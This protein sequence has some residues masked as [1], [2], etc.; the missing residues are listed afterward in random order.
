MSGRRIYLNI[1]HKICHILNPSLCQIC[2][3]GIKPGGFYCAQCLQDFHRVQNACQLCGLPNSAGGSICPACLF[4]PPPWQLMIAPLIYAGAVRSEIQ[5]FKYQ[6][7]IELAH[8]LLEPVSP[9]FMASS[10]EALIPVPLHKSRLLE[11]GFNQS[12]ELA[13]ILSQNTLIPLERNALQRVRATQPQAGLSPHK[14]R[15][16]IRR[17]FEFTPKQRYKSV[18]LIDDI[19]TSGSTMSEISR[20]L[21]RQGVE[22]IQ[23][24]SLAR[25]LKH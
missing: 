6:Q 21:R 15:D 5:R 24:W 22:H 7:H 10:S 19:I 8:A 23:V 20:L 17:A 3:L 14:R 13:R 1:R 12:E 16:N 9:L 4:K 11:R 2:G 25:A 18:V